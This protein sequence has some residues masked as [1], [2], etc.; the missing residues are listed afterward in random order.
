M[1]LISL[2]QSMSGF[3][4]RPA[5]HSSKNILNTFRDNPVLG[6]ITTFGGHPLA[7]SAAAAFCSVLKD[8]VN[9]NEVE[10]LG[11]I[12]EEILTKHPDILCCRRKGMMFAF[13]M[14]SAELVSKVVHKCLEKGLLTFWFLSNPN[15][16]RLSP[17][18]NITEDEITRAGNLIYDAI[19]ESI[20]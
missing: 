20:S 13:D 18:L 11:G 6:H 10:R 17:P 15:S 7:C 19:T 2:L 4:V 12:L 16:F 1:N 3:G 14:E 8:E 5:L 9:L